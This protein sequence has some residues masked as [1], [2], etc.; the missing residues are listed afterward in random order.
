MSAPEGNSL[1]C[2]PE[3]LNVWDLREIQKLRFKN[4]DS[5]ENKTNYFPREQTLFIKRFVYIG[6]I[7]TNKNQHILKTFITTKTLQG[8]AKKVPSIL[9]YPI[10]IIWMPEHYTEHKSA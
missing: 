1:F 5:R 9:N 2:F 8:V 4:W 7:A 6:H 10:V 3:S